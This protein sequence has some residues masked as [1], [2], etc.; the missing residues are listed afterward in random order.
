M[1]AG[2]EP[3]PEPGQN[4]FSTRGFIF[5]RVVPTLILAA[6]VSAAA[7]LLLVW[8]TRE[9][10]RFATE[11]QR[12]LFNMAVTDMT[13][14]IAHEQE[15]VTFWD[16]SVLKLR[17][18]T[19]VEWIDGNLGSWLST[20]FGHDSVYVLDPEN[21]P[22]FASEG[23]RRLPP[24]VFSGV[25]AEVLPLVEAVRALRR[26]A[27]PSDIGEKM[28]SVGASDLAIVRGHPAIVSAKPVISD[29]GTIG[30]PLGQEFVHVAVRYLDGSFLENLGER[31]LFRDLGFVTD[32]SGIA[33]G[34]QSFALADD[35]G[36]TLGYFTWRPMLPGQAVFRNL[37]PV[38][39]GLCA[40]AIL[41]LCLFLWL[42]YRRSAAL[43]ATE[44]RMH[45]MAL[46]D[47]L[48][49]LPNRAMFVTR[50]ERALR[51][52]LSGPGGTALLYVDLD[53]FKRVNDTL[54]HP[55]GDRLIQEVGNRLQRLIRETDTVARFGG[56]EFAIVM[57]GVTEE[58][59]VLHLCER[60]VD[61][62]REP[63]S[64]EG[65][66]VFIGVSI[67]YAIAWSGGPGRNELVRRADVALYRAK[68][69]GR[70]RCVVYTQDMDALLQ[71]RRR[72]ETDLRAALRAGGQLAVYYQPIFA[73]RSRVLTGFEA[74]LRWN[75]PERGAISPEVFIPIAEDIGLIEE[76]GGWVMAEACRTAAGWPGLTISVNVSALELRDPSYASRLAE[77]MGNAGLPAERLE[78]ELT[79]SAMIDSP[80]VHAETLQVLR[81]MGVRLV[82]DDF[83]TGFS[84][85]GRLQSLEV[86]RIK[87]DRSFIQ[88]L[89]RSANDAAIV[90]A[91]IDLAHAT[92]LE[93]TAEGVET[94]EQNAQIDALGCDSVQ[95]FLF[96][97]ALSREHA[98]ALVQARARDAAPEVRLCGPVGDMAGPG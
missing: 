7:V 18:G 76:I 56:D 47:T 61:S 11:G 65:N 91:I 77:L 48:T 59:H 52:S 38:L 82:I 64:I 14:A 1:T 10:D 37:M 26:K 9:A 22:V 46:H 53:H 23:T 75:H 30:E 62:A 33:S 42:L 71:E 40:I 57:A 8:S 51:S 60:I 2:N 97:E 98:C 34:L 13:E 74:L 54:G 90:R 41:G 49:G 5:G 28:D 50:L 83:G 93:T 15:S 87:I 79:E 29:T 72:I 70:N 35:G 63:F 89:G 45:Y 85:L 55:A 6:I 96:S 80:G 58:A 94:E 25:A 95:G 66:Q 69:L 17:D 78:L 43:S 92:V 21:R 3:A 39:A 67:G 86:D 44:A 19:D 73:T 4:Q 12:R 31:Y 24:Q 32:T 88:A 81:R 27:D 84:N 16:D 20:Y 68:S 36:T